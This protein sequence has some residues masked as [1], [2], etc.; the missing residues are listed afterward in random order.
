MTTKR[1]PLMRTEMTRRPDC[2]VHKHLL[3]GESVPAVYDAP[4]QPRGQWG[5]MCEECYDSYA[6]PN[7]HL[8]GTKLRFPEEVDDRPT[9]THGKVVTGDPATPGECDTC[10]WCP[11]CEA[12]RQYTGEKCD[13]CGYV[14]G[15]H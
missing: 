13:T 2:D 4:I 7:A 9:C 14:W 5:Y 11:N 15:E 6:M 8:M 10:D 12:I 1:P 3:G